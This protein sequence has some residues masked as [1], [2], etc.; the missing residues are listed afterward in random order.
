MHMMFTQV[1]LNWGGT[2]WVSYGSVIRFRGWFKG[3]PKEAA[4]CLRSLNM[5]THPYPCLLLCRTS[6]PQSSH[7]F[8]WALILGGGCWLLPVCPVKCRQEGSPLL[9]LVAI[10][11]KQ[12]EFQSFRGCLV[13]GGWEWQPR[14]Q[15][16]RG[17]RGCSPK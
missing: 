12:M 13:T 14:I 2:T 4:H 8:C 9:F 7:R 1:S 17:L 6:A 3:K 11:L 10:F 15:K 5:K 16:P